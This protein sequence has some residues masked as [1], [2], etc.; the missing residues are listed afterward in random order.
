MVE[1]QIFINNK[2]LNLVEL[3]QVG[4]VQGLIPENAINGEKLSRSEG[5]LA[6]Y[7]F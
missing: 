1:A 6:R 7:H 3:S 2:T 5:D 4:V